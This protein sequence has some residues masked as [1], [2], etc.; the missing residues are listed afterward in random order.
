QARGLVA[1]HEAGGRIEKR[2]PAMRGQFEVHY[3]DARGGSAR[4]PTERL[5]FTWMDDPADGVDVASMGAHITGTFTPSSTGDWR[6]SL[7]AVGS[8]TLRIDGDLVVDLTTPQVGA[9][10][11][12]LGSPEIIA[13]VPCEEGVA[14]QV[15][16]TVAVEERAQ[17]RG[18]IVGAAPVVEGDTIA[19]AVEAA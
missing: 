17:L 13:I 3:T 18:L 14:R 11:F 19:P 7:Q 6:I 1:A 5:G 10:F 9:S 4:V 2:L 15:E 12:G 8:A 16:V